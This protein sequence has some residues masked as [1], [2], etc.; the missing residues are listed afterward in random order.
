MYLPV[1][2]PVDSIFSLFSISIASGVRMEDFLFYAS[3]SEAVASTESL[4]T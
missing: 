3:G 2:L 4:L 1:S